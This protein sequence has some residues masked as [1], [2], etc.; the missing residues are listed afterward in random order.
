M[1]WWK[2]VMVGDPEINTSKVQPENS[3]LSDLD[4]ETRQTVEKM[5]VSEDR[6]LAL[7][8]ACK[9]CWCF[10]CIWIMHV[11]LL[12]FML[13]CCCLCAV[14]SASK[15]DGPSHVGR[16]SEAR[17]LGQVHEAG[18]WSREEM[19]GVIISLYETTL[20]TSL[21]PPYCI[22]DDST[23]RWTSARPRST[24]RRGDEKEL[25]RDRVGVPPG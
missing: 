6:N 7:L 19:S 24:E 22:F 9:A 23:L 13:W 20:L 12:M 25:S 10:L 8:L 16:T 1:E 18:A 3:K 14:R 5:M 21:E 4:S 11:I 17:D 2:C 15:A